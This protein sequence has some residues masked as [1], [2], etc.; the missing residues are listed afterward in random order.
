VAG[1]IISFGVSYFASFFLPREWE[2]TLSPGAI[3]AAVASASLTGIIFGY[4]PARNASTL[5][6]VEALS[7]D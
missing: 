2:L 3:A 4:I 5:D 7:R 6:P 1:V